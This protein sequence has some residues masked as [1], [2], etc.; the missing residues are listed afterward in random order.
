GRHTSGVYPLSLHDALPIY[1]KEETLREWTR[2]QFP[3]NNTRRAL[4]FDK[5]ELVYSGP[6]HN[7]ARDAS[8][9][10]FGHTGFTGTFAWMD[11]E[12]GDR[13]STRLNS[14]HVKI[15]YAV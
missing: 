11:P 14:S 2:T 15:S 13:K 7:T 10:S 9:A 5:P 6:G 3:E 1:I 8:A 12:T 4:G